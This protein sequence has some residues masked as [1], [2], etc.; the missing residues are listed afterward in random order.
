MEQGT[1]IG[2]NLVGLNN[3]RIGFSFAEKSSEMVAFLFI[4]VIHNNMFY[5]YFLCVI[6]NK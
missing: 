5:N 1:G 4:K 3:D 2:Q 6:I